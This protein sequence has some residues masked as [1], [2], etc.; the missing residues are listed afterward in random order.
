MDGKLTLGQMF[1]VGFDGMEIDGNHPLIESIV[2]DQLGGVILFDRNVDGTRQN[3][4][5]SSQLRVLTESLQEYAQTPLLISVDQEG[6]R[7]CR[8]R[9]D[10]GF[11]G[12]VSAGFLGRENDFEKTGSYASVIAETLSSHGINFNLAPV[13]DLGLNSENAIINRYDRSYGEDPGHVASH[14][15]AFI[16]SHHKSGVAC[17]LK[18]FPGHGSS[19]GDSH[20]GFV[21]ITDTWQAYELEPYRQLFSFGFSDAVMTAHVVHR[22]LDPDGLPAT[23]SKKIMN[24]LLRDQLKFGGV[25][26]SDDLQMKAITD[27]Y[28]YRTA[29]KMAVL[30]GVDLLIVGNNLIRQENA[31][32]Q[33]IQAVEELLA[34]GSVNEEFIRSALN[35]V[36][37]LKKKIAGEVP[38]NDNTPIT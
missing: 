7:V 8:L 26:V 17:C 31:V 21:D 14:A 27:H 16:E 38:W 12:S 18:H 6:G 1:M 20:L 35:R 30:A 3:I 34:Q 22:R 9:E 33:G 23:L 13:V 29:V 4:I 15:T 2:D 19:T 28:D 36:A 5:S 11:P 25:T 37:N 10:A 24:T 32:S